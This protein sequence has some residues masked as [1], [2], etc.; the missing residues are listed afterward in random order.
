MLK[1]TI[2]PRRLSDESELYLLFC[3]LEIVLFVC[4]ICLAAD[5]ESFEEFVKEHYAKMD[6]SQRNKR[7]F[8]LA[9][10]KAQKE[11]KDQIRAA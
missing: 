4:F 2:Y 11:V 1:S 6:H 8:N 7:K 5:E 9:A 3:H 10:L